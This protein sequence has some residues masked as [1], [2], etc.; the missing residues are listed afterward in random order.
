MSADR[1]E[2][3]LPELLTDLSQ[4][5]V[6]D[7]FDDVLRQTARASQRPAWSFPERWIPMDI[8]ARVPVGTR[9]IPWGRFGIIALLIAALLAVAALYA[10]SRPRPAP[11]FGPAAN[12]D[13]LYDRGGDI[14]VADASGTNERLLIGG[15]DIDFG[16]RYSADGLT[17]FF[18]RETPE[19][20]IVM[21]ANSDG[22]NIDRVSETPLPETYG[23]V[24]VA[25][26]GSRLLVVNM[27]Q[28]EQTLDVHDLVG[29]TEPVVLELDGDV[30]LHDHAWWRP[31]S[32]EIVFRGAGER[33]R[34]LYAINADGTGFRTISETVGGDGL[35]NEFVLSPDGSKA[36]YYNW[37]PGVTPGR[38][39]H[40]HVVDL[41]TGKDV[42][43]L[44]DRAATDEGLPRFLADGRILMRVD[45]N[46]DDWS[47]LLVGPA[48]GSGG[49][50]Q[51]GPAFARDASVAWLVSPDGDS[52]LLFV[53]GRGTKR[54][55]IATGEVVDTDI[56]VPDSW[57][58]Q[59]RAP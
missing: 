6:P 10:G 46:L 30:A 49:G 56:D 42:R 54:I 27:S 50:K 51:V 3:R 17:I 16:Q 15:S 22:S 14:Y 47:A 55:S 57:S 18:G 8:S 45:D 52:V 59:R 2:R 28:A 48:D 23:S 29:D 58:W 38:G 25:P 34:G 9:I 53:A 4:P 21:R 20:T 39:M 41:T 31:G 44:F 33:V 12:G 35:Y 26:D 7:Y 37:E 1:F 24:E 43:L 11:L 19:G 13:I 5:G 36:A 32:D 40:G